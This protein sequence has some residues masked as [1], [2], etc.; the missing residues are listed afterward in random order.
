MSNCALHFQRAVN[1]RNHVIV[2]LHLLNHCTCLLED[3]QGHEVTNSGFGGMGDVMFSL[4]VSPIL[5]FSLPNTFCL[6]GDAWAWRVAIIMCLTLSDHLCSHS[7]VVSR[8][9]ETL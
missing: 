2:A 1:G 7:Y 8:G 5:P 3:D 4:A 9:T 6:L